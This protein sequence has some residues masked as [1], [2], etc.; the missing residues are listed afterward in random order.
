MTSLFSNGIT[1]FE[2]G[3]LL[4]GGGTLPKYQEKGAVLTGLSSEADLESCI[5]VN[6]GPLLE[7]VPSKESHSLVIAEE[8]EREANGCSNAGDKEAEATGTAN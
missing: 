8:E 1:A 4:S 7:K 6:A 5:E 3:T 2:L